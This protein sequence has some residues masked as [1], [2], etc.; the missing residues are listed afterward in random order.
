MNVNQVLIVS[1]VNLSLSDKLDV[2]VRS[3]DG[4]LCAR[5]WNI[6]D[7]VNELELCDRCQKF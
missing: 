6:F 7:H 2:V 3:A 4:K 1:K 5:C